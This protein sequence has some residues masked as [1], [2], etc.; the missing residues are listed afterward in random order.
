MKKGTLF[1]ILLVL[2][3]L[4]VVDAGYLTYEHFANTL[5]T[6]SGSIFVDCGKVLKSPYSVIF[7][8]PLTLLGLIDYLTLFF[9]LAF[10]KY[11]RIKL[12]SKLLIL[13]SFAGFLFSFYLVFAFVSEFS[14]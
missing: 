3:T 9:Y 11:K 13:Q 5:P 8:I 6:C 14:F 2:A 1:Q 12:V 7:G 10:L 4:G